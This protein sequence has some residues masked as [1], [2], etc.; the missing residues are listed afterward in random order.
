MANDIYE[1]LQN[2]H[3]EVE[4]LLERLTNASGNQRQQILD[5]LAITLVPHTK[6]EEVSFYPH[7]QQ[8]QDGRSDTEIAEQQHSMA[9]ELIG[10][11]YEALDASEQEFNEKCQL[12]DQTVRQHIRFEESEMFKLARDSFD[13][14]EEHQILEDFQQAKEE[15]REAMQ[16]VRQR[17]LGREP[18]A[19][20]SA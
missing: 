18:G 4:G 11:C 20:P 19:Q 16:R 13:E 12:L 3:R 1:T 14:E 8:V 10:E 9:E 17:P 5:E 15:I 6:A 7:V 2:D